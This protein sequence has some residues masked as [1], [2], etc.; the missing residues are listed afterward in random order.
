MYFDIFLIWDSF[1]DFEN[2]ILHYT[3]LLNKRL[4]IHKI[5]PTKWD[6]DTVRQKDTLAILSKIEKYKGFKILLDIN[7]QC[8]STLELYERIK[9]KSKVGFFIGWP[10]GIEVDRLRHK[11]D[12]ILSIWKLTMSHLVVLTV[13]LEQSYRLYTLQINKKYH[14]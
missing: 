2:I 11:V 3:K 8:L 9:L 14:Y 5:K 13:I 6:I 10:Y 1:K 12:T 7:G 4:K